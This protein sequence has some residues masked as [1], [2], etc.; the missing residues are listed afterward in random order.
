MTVTSR[1]RRQGSG[2]RGVA[3]LE[4]A[5]IAP[6]FFLLI[7]AVFEFGLFFRDSLT[8]SDAA[9]D[10]ARIGAIIGQ[11]SDSTIVNADFQMMKKIREATASI[12]VGNIERIVFFQATGSAA[13][14][15][16]QQIT[17]ACRRGVQTQRCVVYEDPI[18]AFV[19]VQN[20]NAAFF[21]C[22][23]PCYGPAER[24]EGPNPANIHFLGVYVRMSHPSVTG[25]LADRT[26]E[27]AS[28]VRLE[29][30]SVAP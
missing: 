9:A 6:V 2:E 19:A 3:L 11:D 16:L 27:Q 23:E 26:I 8:L 30:G 24:N 7:F 14:D 4:T 10:A 18:A 13:A 1:R 21:Q 12:D 29:P 17:A 5:I 15:P 20:N 22:T 25:I 28:V